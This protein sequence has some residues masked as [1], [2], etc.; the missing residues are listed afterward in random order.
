M[1]FP[2]KVILLLL[3]HMV[4]IY[5]IPKV[6]LPDT[7]WGPWSPWSVCSRTCGE[8]VQTRRRVCLS[9]DGCDG[10]AIA[11]RACG[12]HPC[13]QSAIS[14]R[15]E[16]CAKY[17][18]IAYHGKYHLWES[19]EK[20]DS[21]CSLDCQAV[22]QPSIVNMFDNQ[23]EDGTRCKGSSLKLCLSGICEEI[24]C[25][26]ELRTGVKLDK[27]G[28]CGGN[29]SSCS[30]ERYI[31]ERES[32]SR[33][34]VSCGGGQKMI[35]YTCKDKN[36][37]KTIANG[38]CDQEVKPVGLFVAC[39]EE[40]CPSRWEVSE[41]S[42]C[43]SS[44]SGLRTRSVECVS[45][46]G[47]S[48][49]L[50]DEKNCQGS[51]PE[52]EEPCT[53]RICPSWYAGSWSGC[54]VSCGSGTR[55]RSV[56]CRNTSGE[57]SSECFGAKPPETQ[58]CHSKCD[59]DE[60]QEF[61]S[62]PGGWEK[63]DELE[64]LENITNKDLFDQYDDETWEDEDSEDD[65]DEE[66]IEPTRKTKVSTNPN[67]I[68]DLW[69][70]CSASCGEGIRFR[71]VECKI[72]L[73]FSKTVATLPDRECP[74]LKP[75]E[76]EIC[77]D[78]PSCGPDQ[79]LS[80]NVNIVSETLPIVN[81]P[82][83]L[84][85]ISEEEKEPAYAWK[86][87]GFTTCTASCLGGLQESIVI[88]V[89]NKKETPVA[90]YF[91]DP[92]KRL[93]IE[94]RTCNE[95]PCPPRWNVSDFTQ[96]TKSCGGGIQTRTV[97][98]IQ[99]VAHGGNNIITLADS[100]CPQPPP[101]AQQ[102]CNVI[103]CPTEWQTSPWTK[104]SQ[105]CGSGF[106]YRKVRCQQ[107]LSLGQLID[108]PEAQCQGTKPEMEEICNNNQCQYVNNPKIKA[109]TEQQ[110]VQ[111]DPYQKAVKLK[112]GGRAT[113][114]I[115]TT[116]KV[117]CPVKQYDKTKITWAQGNLL[118]HSGKK[119]ARHS[120]VSVSAKGGLKIKNIG[121]ND[122]GVYTCMASKSSAQLEIFVKGI[123]PHLTTTPS[124]ITERQNDDK[125]WLKSR[126]DYTTNS[127][128]FK[129]SIFDNDVQNG[130]NSNDLLDRPKHSK[131]KS[132]SYTQNQL[133]NR[134]NNAD[135][136][137]KKDKWNF[138]RENDMLDDYIYWDSINNHAE[139]PGGKRKSTKEIA[140][141]FLSDSISAKKRKKNRHKKKLNHRQRK[142]QRDYPLTWS[143][144]DWSLCS[145]SCGGG[146]QFRQ[147]R[148]TMR[149]SERN[150]SQNVPSNFCKEAK[151]RKPKR[152]RSCGPKNCPTWTKSPW[153]P[154]PTAECMSRK[155]GL[156]TRAVH[157]ILDKRSIVNDTFCDASERPGDSQPCHNEECVGVWVL[158]EWSECSKTCNK[159]HRR[160]SVSCEWLKGGLAP[161]SECGHEERPASIIDCFGPACHDWPQNIQFQFEKDPKI[162]ISPFR[163]GRETSPCQ[164]T[165]KFCGLIKTYKMCQSEKFLEQCCQ[166][167]KAL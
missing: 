50:V 3:I 1:A 115:G 70:P 141:M 155:T 165:S 102:F 105:K 167:C 71:K 34:S 64:N 6:I 62:T 124:Y 166:T 54:S 80:D 112:V 66:E 67:F 28:V 97:Q 43:L 126:D 37:N 33:C 15:D 133:G 51:K 110:Y 94:V 83:I 30:D 20:A 12:L 135:K 123:E 40:A 122:G 158:G 31:W 41:W 145:K 18:N 98:C 81:G 61:S 46:E 8:G 77:V 125:I 129:T 111:S 131:G 157:C 7:P 107:L 149:L 138:H 69:S 85:L 44:C 84:P 29:G 79:I 150:I 90:P 36:Y 65:M 9:T 10:S 26:L 164:D 49:I 152:V 159:G 117:R 118:Y 156:R 16:Q 132:N 147:L 42:H 63:L 108:K 53:S 154:C 88:C 121:F 151:L 38:F 127:H 82:E 87:A 137:S 95:N 55:Q 104:C 103:D 17:N 128:S 109:N 100:A 142:T 116:V 114:Y 45:D 153:A 35:Q 75:P 120:K 144:G 47:G 58:P 163:D 74:G 119:R 96:C 160:R 59:M 76:T 146:E 91:C 56:I 13:P 106:R 73:E 136:P 14:W 48:R 72:F 22:D 68:I 140:D 23:V 134:R 162:V 93:E 89:E 86:I 5:S 25:D 161:L 148:C 60:Y 2:P 19:V 99:E 130:H 101:R 113:V 32:L 78:K 139:I 11:W 92:S 24:G 39:N 4:S 52:S 27:C 57:P 143:P 21:P